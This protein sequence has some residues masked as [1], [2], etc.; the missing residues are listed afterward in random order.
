MN[1]KREFSEL[2]IVNKEKYVLTMEFIGFE[3]KHEV[4]YEKTMV[5]MF[6]V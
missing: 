5:K 1:A 4:D 2:N 3:P 6:Q